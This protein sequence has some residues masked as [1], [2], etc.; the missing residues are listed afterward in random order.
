[1]TQENIGTGLPSSLASHKCLT[2][3]R[4]Y[5]ETSLV[6]ENQISTLLL[7]QANVVTA[8]L[9]DSPKQYSPTF[10]RATAQ[11][12][13]STYQPWICPTAYQPQWPPSLPLPRSNYKVKLAIKKKKSS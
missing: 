9:Q 12:N 2:L 1:M 7:L 5:A 3:A 4:P 8:T 6:Q 10:S 13:L 11:S